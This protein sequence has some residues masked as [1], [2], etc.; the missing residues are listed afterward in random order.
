MNKMPNLPNLNA[1]KIF[2]TLAD[3][4]SMKTTSELYGVSMSAVS[5]TISALEAQLGCTLIDRKVRPLGLTLAG[6]LLAKEGAKLV[7][8]AHR[9]TDTLQTH[10]LESLNLRIGFSESV[11][12]SIAPFICAGLFKKVKTFSAQTAMT[13]TLREALLKRELDILISPERFDEEV[14]FSRTPLWT[15]AYLLVLPKN[16]KPVNK[17]SELRKLASRL[18]YIRFNVDS[19]DRIQCERV[20]RQLD[21]EQKESFGVESSFSMVGLVAQ[22][23]GWAIMPPWGIWQGHDW[24]GNLQIQ[25]IPQL[26][27]KRTQWIVSASRGL[28]PL[29]QVIK[30][31]ALA[32][33]SRHLKPWLDHYREGLSAFVEIQP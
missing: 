21:I 2:L 25:P 3:C 20:F 33:Y 24:I 4:G 26:T 29:V 14:S 6:R 5:Q 31:D 11:S 22:G 18:P 7:L 1:L 27:V 16:E 10:S 19:T 17:L 30:A 32:G 13:Q 9:L 8:D 15:E 28:E 12:H 23:L